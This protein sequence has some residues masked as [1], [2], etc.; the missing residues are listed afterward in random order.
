[1]G[2]FFMKYSLLLIA[3]LFVMAA[4]SFNTLSE[5]LTDE[6]TPLDV[7]V[8]E[9]IGSDMITHQHMYDNM[10]RG[11]HNYVDKT[12]VI[13]TNINVSKISRGDVVFFENEDVEKDISRVIALPGE[14]IKIAKGQIYINGKKLDTFY[15]KAHRAGLDKESYFD[16]MDKNGNHYDEKGMLA[17]F[18]MN[19][20]EIELS[21]DEYYLISDDWLRGKMTGLNKDKM[22]GKVVGYT[23]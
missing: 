13:D 5:P 3:L 15:G 10:D 18:E 4:C 20:K 12:L 2:G 16:N 19:M 1:M 21:D 7:A 17:V 11:N 6:I 22:I 23:K 8:I 9:N 14:K